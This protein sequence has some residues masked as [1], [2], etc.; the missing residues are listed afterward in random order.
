MHHLLWGIGFYITCCVF[1]TA[2][3][4]ASLSLCVLSITILLC[5]YVP[6]TIHIYIFTAFAEPPTL[7]YKYPPRYLR[8]PL[9]HLAII[10][11][12]ILSKLSLAR[13]STC[14]LANCLCQ[15]ELFGDSRLFIRRDSRSSLSCSLQISASPVET[16]TKWGFLQSHEHFRLETWEDGWT[17]AFNTGHSRAQSRPTGSR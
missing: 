14:Y 10:I 3:A 2:A 4:F 6:I 9:L 8:L 5:Q 15:L 7:P 11:R 13:R 17:R 1:V 16:W 12:Y